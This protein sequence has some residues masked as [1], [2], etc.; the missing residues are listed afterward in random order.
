MN[1]AERVVAEVRT[2]PEFELREVLDF[3]GYLKTRR[4]RVEDPVNNATEDVGFAD[5]IGRLSNSATFG[6]DPLALQHRLRDEWRDE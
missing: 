3:V 6:G 2:L 5:F 1:I 4:D